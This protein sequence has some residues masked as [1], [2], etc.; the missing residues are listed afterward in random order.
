MESPNVYDLAAL[1]GLPGRPSI[2]IGNFD[3]VHLG[4]LE[5]LEALLLR[6]RQ[7]AEAAVV[8]TF[9]PHPGRVLHPDRP[10]P[11]ITTPS[12]KARLL[13]Q[14]GVDQT[15]FLRFTHELAQLEAEQFIERVLVEAL[16]AGQVVTTPTFR[17]GH[18]RG[19]DTSTLEV[20]GRRL[21]F[22]VE[23][24]G[25]RDHRGRAISSTRIREH[26]RRGAVEAAAEMLGRPYSI[27]GTVVRGVGRGATLGF[28]TANLEPENEIFM[29]RGVYAVQVRGP[30]PLAFGLTNVGIRPTFDGETLTVETH[31]LEFGG[32]LLGQ[33]LEILF[34][35]RLR[36]E[37]RFA[38][39]AELA[40]Q[41][42]R[43]IEAARQLFDSAARAA[44]G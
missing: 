12:Q 25:E 44:R 15:L 27:E 42:R 4:H 3:G 39:P 31:L 6:A 14:V 34:L 33:R 19:G 8:L 17:F 9:E 10:L 21:G 7:R 40:Q 26:L 11:E 36:D 18:N 35:H 20:C 28:P 23:L 43:D 2:T 22:A 38:G 1:P 29:A 13:K 41:I 16:H 24:V 5:V 37:R 32:S 30:Q